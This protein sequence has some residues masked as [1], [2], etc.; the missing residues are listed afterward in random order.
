MGKTITR[1]IVV[2]ALM[3]G[4]M[5]GTAAS[6]QASTYIASECAGRTGDMYQQTVRKGTNSAGRQ[7]Y[8]YDLMYWNCNPADY[9]WVKYIYHFASDT[10]CTQIHVAGGY[11]HWHYWP[12]DVSIAPSWD[13]GTRCNGDSG[14]VYKFTLSGGQGGGGSW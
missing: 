2:L 10:P 11:R 1:A 4:A 14:A 5:V 9:D 6:S 3:A 7:A 8:Y 13:H 12:P